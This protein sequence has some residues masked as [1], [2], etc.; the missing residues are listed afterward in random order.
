MHEVDWHPQLRVD[1]DA[2]V[3]R[4]GEVR[5]VRRL[6]Q[7]RICFVLQL[8]HLWRTLWGFEVRLVPDADDVFPGAGQRGF[9][10]HG[11][12]V[13]NVWGVVVVVVGGMGVD[14]RLPCD[15]VIKHRWSRNLGRA[16]M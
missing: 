11:G 4:A 12:D 8:D 2:D 6:E 16:V 3:V 5:D 10:R 13:G 1:V 14:G 9:G 15:R 7:L